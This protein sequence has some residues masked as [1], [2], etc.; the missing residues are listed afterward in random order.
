VADTE[1]ADCKAK[2]SL[3]ASP[4]PHVAWAPSDFSG[5]NNGQRESRTWSNSTLRLLTVWE[6]SGK[7]AIE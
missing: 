1:L 3:R 5:L 2:V 7:Q 6:L 4:I